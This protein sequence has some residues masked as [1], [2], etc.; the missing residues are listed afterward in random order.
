LATIEDRYGEITDNQEEQLA[1]LKESIKAD[2]E[3][4]GLMIVE[5]EFE[6][7]MERLKEIKKEIDKQIEY[8]EDE[9]TKIKYQLADYLG[10]FGPQEII[11]ADGGIKYLCLGYTVKRSINQD[12]VHIDDRKYLI[13]V[14]NTLKEFLN[15]STNYPGRVINTKRKDNILADLNEDDPA[16]SKKMNPQIKLNKTNPK[17]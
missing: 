5:K 7:R 9:K 6:S 8:L 17:E 2:V 10:E 13:E 12:E 4:Y 15:N 16:I 3:T 11:L 14:D 1:Q